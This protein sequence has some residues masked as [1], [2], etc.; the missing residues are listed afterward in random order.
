MRCSDEIR[1]QAKAIEALHPV[2][3]EAA[4]WIVN[5]FAFHWR[6]IIEDFERKFDRV[7][8][9][10]ELIWCLG[11]LLGCDPRRE[12]ARANELCACGKREKA[13][14]RASNCKQ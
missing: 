8:T 10:S 13:D 6:R 1:V 11:E 12:V 4:F 14:C 5:H 7:P 9:A 2:S 3:D